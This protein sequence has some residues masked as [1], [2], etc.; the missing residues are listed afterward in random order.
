MLGHLADIRFLAGAAL[1]S[2]LFDYVFWTLNFLRM[3]TTALTAQARGRGD[4]RSAIL[5]LYRSL[6]LAGAL[7][8][9]L[10][11]LQPLVK[12]LGFSLLEVSAELHGPA[13]DY[14]GA[15]IWGAPATLANFA[16]LGW[17]LGREESGR[18]L[19]MTMTANLA[20]VALNYVFIL[21]L[22]WASFGAGLATAL[23]QYLMLGVAVG[24]F[25]L[26]GRPPAWRR[27]EVLLRH[28][29]RALFQLNGDILLRT[30]FLTSTLAAFTALSSRLGDT[31]VV[32]NTLLLRLMIFVAYFIDGAAFAVESL[33]GILLGLG[34]RR[35]LRRLLRLALSC[36]EVFAAAFLL[37]FLL[38][39][40]PLFRIFTSHEEIIEAGTAFLP[41]LLPVLVL[42]APAFI[43][44][45]LFLGLTA[46][47]RLRNAMMVSSFGVFLPL[48][49]V[50]LATQSNSWLWFALSA[51]M[52]ARALTLAHSSRALVASVGDRHG[53]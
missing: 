10:L 48:A 31:T 16:F 41:W 28:E 34:D 5:V 51:W 19:A 7:G 53:E 40:R 4:D 18:A 26:L 49:A 25:L 14:F 3:S 13:A 29:L 50:A 42:G 43:Y 17:F 2:V 24:L 52:A 35:G 37:G 12:A 32:V 6:T 22:G 8:I 30:L 38:F 47:R 11:I 44:D 1:A 23:S 27:R 45:G 21:Q 20:N 36:S 15:R 9:G 39:P 46:G 33:A